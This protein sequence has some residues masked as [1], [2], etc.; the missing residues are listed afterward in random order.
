[1]D[2]EILIKQPES[3]ILEFKSDLSSLTPILKTIVAFANTAGGIIIIGCSTS[4]VIT[5]IKNIFK[6]E[7]RLANA[8]S[9]SIHP[10]L[11][12]EIEITTIEGKD[13]LIIKVA[14]WKGPFYLK[15]EGIPKG[16]YIRLGSTS[17]PAG[18]ELL[19]ELQRSFL[20]LS[21]DQQPLPDLTKDSLNLEKIEQIFASRGKHIN[22]DKL[23]SLGILVPYA[24]NLVPSIGGL[25]L[26]GKIN[27]LNHYFPDAKVNCARFIG[28]NKSNILD[29]LE[30][31]GTILDAI[32]SVPKFIARNTRLTAQI[33]GIRRKD[34]TEYPPVAIREV[35]I[36]ALVH[37]DY[38]IKGAHIQIAIFNNR[39]EIQNPGM[40]PF[41]FTMEDLKMG[42]SRVRNRVI[43]RVFHELQ[44]MEAWGSGYRRCVEEC[45]SENYPMPE[46]IELGAAVR[47][48]FYPHQKTF[49]KELRKT[50]QKPLH[51]LLKRQKAII[52]LFQPGQQLSF[53]EIFKQLS[54]SI[55]ERTLRYDLAILRDKKLLTS[56]GKGR[57][58]VWQLIN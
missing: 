34:I 35:L 16:V 3:K 19:D 28:D 32:E 13:L 52:A 42:V 39:L 20:S 11:L 25:I 44:L 45:K 40:L 53:R 38:S 21:F 58:I 12:P 7:E 10:P 22:K 17:R 54:E 55:P 29:R 14:H 49:I 8:I 2:I 56:K 27:E 51:D 31:E 33:E 6:E 9:D 41:G 37:N 47:V 36:N 30:I 50:E 48:T 5:G 18:P 15:K 46:W 43:A 1:M 57:A 24:R 4:R 26:F 23:Q